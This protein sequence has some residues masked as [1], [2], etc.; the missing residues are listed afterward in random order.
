[1]LVNDSAAVRIVRSCYRRKH[2]RPRFPPK[3]MCG[4]TSRRSEGNKVSGNVVRLDNIMYV[5]IVNVSPTTKLNVQLVPVA[6]RTN[7]VPGDES[8]KS[9]R[10]EMRD[11]AHLEPV[12]SVSQTARE[13][14]LRRRPLSRTSRD[15]KMQC[16][17]F[18]RPHVR[19]I[20]KV[21]RAS[22]KNWARARRPLVTA[23]VQYLA[24]RECRR[25]A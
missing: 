12:C 19:R 10:F 14:Q 20:E 11:I 13:L 21:S 7:A 17:S 8:E 22:V 4:Q 24:R 2:Y 6:L 16:A 3:R 18:V 9:G 23:E 25:C 15:A 1:M 5:V